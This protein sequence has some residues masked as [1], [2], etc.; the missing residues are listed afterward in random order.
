MENSPSL[1]VL[2]LGE[3]LQSEEWKSTK[4]PL[5][6]ARFAISKIPK[7]HDE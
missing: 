7:D 6:L 5:T 2:T 4:S 3:G 1:N